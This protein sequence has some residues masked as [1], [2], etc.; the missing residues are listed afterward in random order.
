MKIILVLK[1]SKILIKYKFKKNYNPKQMSMTNNI[2]LPIFAIL[3]LAIF[4][5]TSSANAVTPTPPQLTILTQNNQVMT[6]TNS[7]V[8]AGTSA[9]IGGSNPI[10]SVTCK[11]DNGPASNVVDKNSL[12]VNNGGKLP[13]LLP[14]A[15]RN[16]FFDSPVLA[17]GKHVM[18]VTAT[19]SHG[20]STV[21]SISVT[22]NY[23]PP[24]PIHVTI[25]S[26]ADGTTMTDK[27]TATLTGTA[28]GPITSMY[29]RMDNSATHYPI[30]ASSFS[31]WKFTTSVL[32]R[33][34]HTIYVSANA[35]LRDITSHVSISSMYGG[36][37][38]PSVTISSPTNGA[39]ITTSTVTVS[40][41][42]GG[43]LVSAI[44][45]HVDSGPINGIAVT[46]TTMSGFVPWSFTTG[47]LTAGSHVIYVQVLG[48]SGTGTAQISMTK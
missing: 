24:P 2:I 25:L 47:T 13:P 11:I 39:K 6:I 34:A 35:Q 7:V 29:W 17:N 26:P 19:D 15:F 9:A 8:I 40:G 4:T 28:D 43:A 41:T 33:G 46:Q 44:R 42:V 21:A 45:L 32:P 3:I 22:I 38:P 27:N 1:L 12:I 37:N 14:P 48:P 20:A 10:T 23:T 5:Q 31:N 36:I 18:T 30:T 16:W